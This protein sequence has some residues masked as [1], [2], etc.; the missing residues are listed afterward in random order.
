MS[1]ILELPRDFPKDSNEP[2]YDGVAKFHADHIKDQFPAN[3]DYMLEVY[4]SKETLLKILNGPNGQI[5]AGI[6]L[7]SARIDVEYP[8]DSGTKIDS[9]T[10]AAVGVDLKGGLLNGKNDGAFN[11]ARPCPPYCPTW[12]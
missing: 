11:I 9:I 6:V 8:P 10:V 7:Y 5:C 3:S 1:Q 4:I 2:L 12:G